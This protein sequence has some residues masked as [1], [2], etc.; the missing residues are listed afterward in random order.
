MGVPADEAHSD[1]AKE[2]IRAKCVQ[3][4]DRAEK[5]K[6][7]LRSKDKHSKRPVREAQNDNKGCVGNEGGGGFSVWLWSWKD[8]LCH[9]NASLSPEPCSL[10]P[11]VTVTA[12]A[13]TLR[14]RSCRSS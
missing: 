8:T 12:R 6:E 11:G 5:L 3:Y 10:S 4:L 9:T 2:S 7:Y 14:R 1:K 13:R